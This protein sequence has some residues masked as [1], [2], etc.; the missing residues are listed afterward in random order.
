MTAKKFL[1]FAMLLI[2][3]AT[4]TQWCE[5]PIG[6]TTVWW[7]LDALVLNCLYQL[8]KPSKRIIPIFLFQICVFI[9][10]LYGAIFQAE[11]YWDWKLLINNAMVFS[12]PLVVYAFDEISILCASLNFW[13]RYAWIILLVLLPFLG[14]DAYGRFLC[15][16][17]L[18]ALFFPLL[19]TKGKIAVLGAYIITMILGSESR[20][21]TLKFTVCLF[22]G[23]AMMFQALKSLILRFSRPIAITLWITPV[24]FF[25]L[26]AT[27]TFNIFNIEEELGIEDRY[28]MQEGDK[29]ISALAD[30]R[31]LLYVEEINSAINHNYVIHGRSMARGHDSILFGEEIDKAKGVKRGERDSCETSILNIFNYFGLIGVFLYFVIFAS[32]SYLAVSKSMNTYIP[33]VGIYVSFRWLFAWVEDFSRFDLNYLLLWIMIG[34]CFSSRLRNMTDIEIGKW[35]KSIIRY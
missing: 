6:N 5:L 12:L 32:A 25:V 20:S 8:G 34:M 23:L 1:P 14:S 21:D 27:E 15:P 26:G 16:Y 19:N 24:V 3:V 35:I 29:E 2:S 17:T 13:L 18:L 7:I 4:I 28:K 22:I 30:T 33:I 9:S 31:T 11:I 10:F